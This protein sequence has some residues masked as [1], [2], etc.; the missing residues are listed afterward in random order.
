MRFGFVLSS[1]LQVCH[2]FLSP[3]S[4]HQQSIA[5]KITN[6]SC[7]WSKMRH[8]MCSLK[9]RDIALFWKY[10]DYGSLAE[11]LELYLDI[12]FWQKSSLEA[13]PLSLDFFV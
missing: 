10:N 13:Y 8:L 11:K 4:E 12:I 3:A 1:S 9:S 5:N 2:R 7:C 6:Q